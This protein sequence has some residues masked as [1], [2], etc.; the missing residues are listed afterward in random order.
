[1]EFKLNPGRNPFKKD[2]FSKNT[3]KVSYYINDILPELGG[4][5][6]GLLSIQKGSIM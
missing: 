2:Q 1:M 5:M 3:L 4:D 6:E